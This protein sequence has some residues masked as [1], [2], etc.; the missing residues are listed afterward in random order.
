MNYVNLC[1]ANKINMC[2]VYSITYF[3]KIFFE[4]S[5]GTKISRQ[6]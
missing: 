2:R 4:F 5:D 6:K 3:V 1:I